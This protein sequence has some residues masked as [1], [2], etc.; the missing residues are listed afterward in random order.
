MRGEQPRSGAGHGNCSCLTH[1][2]A[3]QE[4]WAEA[5]RGLALL[6]REGEWKR[7]LSQIGRPLPSGRCRPYREKRKGKT[8]T[9]I[10]QR[11]RVASFLLALAGSRAV[12]ALWHVGLLPALTCAN[13]L[14]EPGACPP[15][16]GSNSHL[17]GLHVKAPRFLSHQNPIIGCQHSFHPRP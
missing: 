11:N 4:P 1:S 17:H 6:R 3:A 10:A 2:P 5:T 14:E 12:H 13:G 9:A 16:L 15:L 8:S 7:S